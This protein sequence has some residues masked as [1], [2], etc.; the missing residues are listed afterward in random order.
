MSDGR[1]IYLRQVADATSELAADAGERAVR[2]S[3]RFAADSSHAGRD[4]LLFHTETGPHLLLVNGSQIFKINE[5]LARQ[6]V[7][8][9]DNGQDSARSVLASHR[10]GIQDFVGDRPLVNPP[11]RAL[12]LNVTNHCNLGCVYCYADGGSFGGRAGEMSL[13]VAESAVRS[14][15]AMAGPGE[16]VSLAFLG[17]EPLMN[18]AVMRGATELAAR[19]AGESGKQVAFSITTN[20][21]LLTADDCEFFERFRFA[22]TISLDAVREVN[23]RLRPMRRGGGSY[24]RV[25]ANVRPL[26][27]RRQHA[28]VSA[29]VTVTPANLGLREVL[30]HFVDMGF[31]SIGF[32][33]VL[34]APTRCGEMQ[35]SDLEL[36][37]AEMIACGRE[38]ERRLLAGDSYPFANLI[39]ALEEIHR[40][41]HRPYPC[42]AGGGYF[43]VSA[44]GR[45]YACHRFVEDEAAAMGTLERGVDR[46]R[47]RL[48]LEERFV[49]KQEPCRDCWARY[50]C[51][52]GCHHEVIHRGRPACDYIRGWL[53]YALETYVR[54]SPLIPPL[55]ARR[56]FQG[57][58]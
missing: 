5:E 25:I 20:G 13:E 11:L 31:D 1:R 24:D 52:G 49:D 10:L 40:G 27:A 4:F 26:L 44:S 22:V 7:A 54:I 58:R 53:R 8:A 46:N 21:T 41:T 42:G 14:L 12:S 2:S 28:Q 36:L 50:L 39:S 23:D 33:P 29:R 47:Q 55:L 17:G 51:G 18:R 35:T 6:L 56:Q 32:S 15:L 45:L 38:F 57:R 37:L 30:D 48:W 34:S 43:G 3:R 19:I 16:R 9:S